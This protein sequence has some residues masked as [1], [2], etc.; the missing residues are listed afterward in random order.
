MT[1]EHKYLEQLQKKLSSILIIKF[2]PIPNPLPLV[3]STERLLKREITIPGFVQSNKIVGEIEI[4]SLILFHPLKGIA[5]VGSTERLLKREILRPLL[6]K[7]IIQ[8]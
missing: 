1:R 8:K 2:D 3:G 6:L 4:R 5:L 7:V